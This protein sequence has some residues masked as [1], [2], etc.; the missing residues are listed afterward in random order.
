V[1]SGKIGAISTLPTL[2]PGAE[3][4]YTVLID[5]PDPDGLLV[6]GLTV[7]VETTP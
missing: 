7:E 1:L 3:S 6:W 2:K 5:I 4:L